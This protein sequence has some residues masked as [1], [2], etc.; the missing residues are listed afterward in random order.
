VTGHSQRGWYSIRGQLLLPCLIEFGPFGI[1]TSSINRA[2][3]V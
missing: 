1:S 2:W 3:S